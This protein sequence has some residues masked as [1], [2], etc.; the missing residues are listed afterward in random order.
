MHRAIRALIGLAAAT[1]VIATGA[2]AASAASAPAGTAP[3]SA[4]SWGPYYSKYYEGWRAHATGAAYMDHNGRLVVGGKLYDRGSPT[5]L[6]GYVQIRYEDFEP[7]DRGAQFYSAK[8][9][10]RGYRGFRF[11][12]FGAGRASVRAC[13]TDSHRGRHLC[14]KWHYVYDSD[15]E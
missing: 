4:D 8:H 11:S 13:Y 3:T 9:C 10:G 14:G 12:E 15:E 7:D 5:R 6:C 2:P 1:A